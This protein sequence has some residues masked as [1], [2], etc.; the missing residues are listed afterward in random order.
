MTEDGKL[1]WEVIVS[2]PVDV[3]ETEEKTVNVPLTVSVPVASSVTELLNVTRVD[4]ESAAV[5]VSEI[6]EKNGV[7]LLVENG[8]SEKLPD[9]KAI[10]HA[11][12]RSSS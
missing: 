5:A 6:E 3:S 7:P 9:E 1:T 10:D 2:D 4:A 8:T 11:P 12:V